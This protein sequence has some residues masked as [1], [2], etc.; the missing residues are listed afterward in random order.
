[1][2]VLNL[3]QPFGFKN[4]ISNNLTRLMHR[5]VDDNNDKK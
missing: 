3:R 4:Q 1:M 2:I 5:M